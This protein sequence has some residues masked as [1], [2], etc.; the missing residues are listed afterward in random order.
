[1]K[2][3]STCLTNVA[4]LES[5]LIK[6]KHRFKLYANIYQR[7]VD[8][9]SSSKNILYGFML[10]NWE[11]ILVYNLVAKYGIKMIYQYL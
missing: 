7:Q 8:T 9:M 1:M 10:I 6:L 2:W 11:D 5:V 3:H 4:W